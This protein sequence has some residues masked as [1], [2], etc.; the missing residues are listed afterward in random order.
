MSASTTT[1]S[2]A[3]GDN[4]FDEPYIWRGGRFLAL[5]TIFM[6]YFTAGVAIWL[7]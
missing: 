6:V 5:Y 1:N 3:A 2:H 7:L 4:R